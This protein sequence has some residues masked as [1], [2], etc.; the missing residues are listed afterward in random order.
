MSALWA[1]N[2][3]CAHIIGYCPAVQDARIKRH[4]Y[5]CE[6]LANEEKK[7]EWVV[8]PGLLLRDNCNELYKPDLVFVKGD[9]ALVVD[10]TVRFESKPTSLAAAATKKVKKYQYLRNQVQELTN[11]TN[12]KFMGFPLSA[13][14]KWYQGDHE[15][16]TDLG[17]SSS[18]NEKVARCLPNRALFTS[19]DIIHIYASKSQTVTA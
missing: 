13:R 19:V 8:F 3:N 7:K 10:I 11:T 9:Q 6:L 12:I 4:N 15:L 14:G 2:K 1:D 5:L 18:R 17:L 16:L